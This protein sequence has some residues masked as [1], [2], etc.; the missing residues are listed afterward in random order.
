MRKL[1]TLL[2]YISSNRI[3]LVTLACLEL[4]FVFLAWFAYPEN[5]LSLVGLM[6]FVSL[7]ALILPLVISIYKRKKIDIAFRCFLLEPDDR[8]EYLLCE[9]VPASLRPYLRELGQHLRTQQEYGKE[10]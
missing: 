5:F 3:W 1:R 8:N 2:T 10:Q 9:S 4:F 7:A 6:I